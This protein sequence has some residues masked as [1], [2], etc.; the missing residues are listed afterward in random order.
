[1]EDRHIIHAA[2]EWPI[3]GGALKDSAYLGVYDGHGGRDMVDFLEHSLSRHLAQE[4]LLE[5]ET[6]STQKRLERA[7]LVTDIHAQHAGISSS[8]ATVACCIIKVRTRMDK[9]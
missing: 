4:L 9:T 1:M 5:D 6:I 7:F 2:G 3:E 8:G